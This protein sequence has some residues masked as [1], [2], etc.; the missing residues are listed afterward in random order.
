MTWD[1]LSTN[2][3]TVT[4]CENAVGSLSHSEKVLHLS[5]GHDGLGPLSVLSVCSLFVLVP[6]PPTIQSHPHQ[7]NWRC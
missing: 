2:S 7:V 3:K 1:E 6:F 4:L 5:P